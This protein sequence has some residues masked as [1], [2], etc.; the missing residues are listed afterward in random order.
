MR[1]CI[2]LLSLAIIACADATGTSGTPGSTPTADGTW[3]AT[4]N[5]GGGS[6]DMVFT[7]TQSGATITGNGT[8]T[9]PNDPP[10]AI[11]TVT[12]TINGTIVGLTLQVQPQQYMGQTID[13]NKAAMQFTGTLTATT[14]NGMLNGGTP[15]VADV[16]ANFTKQ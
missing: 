11:F 12:G 6:G 15:P 4:I 8:F 14:L 3:K 5:P 13:Q 1:P 9:D 2:A 7:L 10:P 16:T